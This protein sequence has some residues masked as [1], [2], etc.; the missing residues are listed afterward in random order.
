MYLC[1]Y[2]CMCVYVCVCV[3][4]NMYT[5]P[6]SSS[7]GFKGSDHSRSSA[8]V[9][10]CTQCPPNGEGRPQ[11]RPP[12]S[13]ISASVDLYFCTRKASKLST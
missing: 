2:V 10:D 1:M 11:V 7:C 4:V 5:S 8:I 13:A 6:S 3:C 12:S 9:S